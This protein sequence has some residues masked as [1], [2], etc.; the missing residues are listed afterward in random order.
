MEQ[1][2]EYN[3]KLLKFLASENFRPS[4]IH[5]IGL[6]VNPDVSSD[7]RRL[8]ASLRCLIIDRCTLPKGRNAKV[9]KISLNLRTLIVSNCDASML[10]W[11]IGGAPL[12]KFELNRIAG[13]GTWRGWTQFHNIE[14]LSIEQCDLN[15]T[16]YSM[17]A[18]NQHCLVHL[19][20]I[21]VFS[22]RDKVE[23]FWKLFTRLRFTRLA[24]LIIGYSKL[25]PAKEVF[26][27]EISKV[28]PSLQ[29]FQDANLRLQQM[30]LPHDG[31]AKVRRYLQSSKR[32]YCEILTS[33]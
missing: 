22:D 8:L 17:L 14:S 21:K 10:D 13:L 20:L 16:F 33:A 28:C 2:R 11:V 30:P 29:Q 19:S 18:R 26:L 15:E 32:G 9:K 24:T 6:E 5:L 4:F 12:V 31:F 27:L 25:L 7:L 1:G 23:M 3:R